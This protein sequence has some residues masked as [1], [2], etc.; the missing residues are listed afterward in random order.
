MSAHR[1]RSLRWD[2]SSRTNRSCPSRCTS[3][4]RRCAASAEI[5]LALVR[6]GD[7]SQS[8]CGHARVVAQVGDRTPVTT[9]SLTNYSRNYSRNHSRPCC[10]I[11]SNSRAIRTPTHMR[12]AV[13]C[14]VTAHVGVQLGCRRG[15]TN[16]KYTRPLGGVAHRCMTAIMCPTAPGTTPATTP[17][18]DSSAAVRPGADAEKWF[19]VML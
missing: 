13:T 16:P 17:V 18:G 9:R 14:T 2:S 10:P 8:M 6:V 3:R 19:R 1:S 11:G 4:R 7:A 5:T 15:D 12:K